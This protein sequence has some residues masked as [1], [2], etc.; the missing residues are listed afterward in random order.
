MVNVSLLSIISNCVHL[1]INAFTV[2]KWEL[3]D[4]GSEHGIGL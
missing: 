2:H 1:M 3:A 4:L